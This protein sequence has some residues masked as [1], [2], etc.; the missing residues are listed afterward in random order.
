M[1]GS[2]LAH[3][4]VVWAEVSGAE[5]LVEAYYTGGTKLGDARVEV[6]DARSRVLLRG[7]T[8][9]QGRFAFRPPR[10]ED[11][12]IRVVIRVRGPG[13]HHG[14]FELKAEEIEAGLKRDD[15]KRPRLQI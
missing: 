13:D 3:G 15:L 6:L 2:V 10:A 14:R 5:V 9:P 1:A 12:V 11:L 8:D 7:Y 4:V